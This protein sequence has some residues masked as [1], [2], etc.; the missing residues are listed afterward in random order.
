MP[1]A[2]CGEHALEVWACIRDLKN[3]K[4]RGKQLTAKRALYHLLAHPRNYSSGSVYVIREN[5]DLLQD[6]CGTEMI[7]KNVLDHRGRKAFGP[8]AEER[9]LQEKQERAKNK[10]TLQVGKKPNPRVFKNA[11][12]ARG[13]QVGDQLPLTKVGTTPRRLLPLKF[14]S[15]DEKYIWHNDL[16]NYLRANYV[17]EENRVVNLSRKCSSVADRIIKEAK[18]VQ[19]CLSDK[20]CLDK[21]ASR[22]KKRRRETVKAGG[23]IH[24]GGETPTWFQPQGEYRN[25][26]VAKRDVAEYG[27]LNH[28]GSDGRISGTRVKYMAEAPMANNRYRPSDYEHM[29]V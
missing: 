18:I 17:D 28:K 16:R 25:L 27:Y 5:Q 21:I 4:N 7:N 15:P 12:G 8:E 9:F 13:K 2:Y 22:N 23:T 10:A 1:F 19:D 6:I 3:D 24:Q 14:Y 20:A 29:P 26:E 11:V